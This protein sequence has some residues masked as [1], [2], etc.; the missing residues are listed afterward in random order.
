M[1]TGTLA[2]WTGLTAATLSVW[3]NVSS[4]P[5][6]TNYGAVLVDGT[7]QTGMWVRGISVKHLNYEW[8]GQAVADGTAVLATAIW[9]NGVLTWDGTNMIGYLNGVSD[10]TTTSGI[11]QPVPSGGVYGGRDGGGDFLNA[12]IAD[13]AIWNV[14]LTSL[15]VTALSR[16]MRP[17]RIRPLN[18]KLWI[19]HDGL[20][21]PEP[22]LAGSATNS[23]LSGTTLAFG[24][25][26]TIATPRRL[27]A[28][29]F[30]VPPPFILMPQIVT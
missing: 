2:A 14:A 18:L 29:T 15:E 19:P 6:T 12:A 26:F 3:F 24:P 9:Y 16:G 21:S 22:D 4:F 13:Q 23:S 11:A 27:Q 17:N 30:P 25:P 20:Q 8:R 7:G 5:A 10:L 28:Q 1:L